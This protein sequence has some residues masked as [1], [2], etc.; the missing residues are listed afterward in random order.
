MKG[1]R[2]SLK[3]G[4]PRRLRAHFEAVIKSESEFRQLV[5]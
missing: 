1:D 4:V 5:P 3:V 2:P